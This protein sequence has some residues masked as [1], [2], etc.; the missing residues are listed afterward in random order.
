MGKLILLALVSSAIVSCSKSP[1]ENNPPVENKPAGFREFRID[2]NKSAFTVSLVGVDMGTPDYQSVW[3][4]IE[5]AQTNGLIDNIVQ[6][7]VPIEGGIAHCVEVL[8]DNHREQ[9]ISEL[10][11][12]PTSLRESFYTVESVADCSL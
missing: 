1:L 8:N 4:V 3:A 11:Q 12:T 10:R 7:A 2:D 9:I 5:K 6:F